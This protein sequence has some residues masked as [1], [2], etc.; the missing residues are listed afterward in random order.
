MK[1]SFFYVL[2]TVSLLVFTPF[3]TV[4]ARDLM[5]I[6]PIL[7]ENVELP[8]DNYKSKM[9]AF[10]LAQDTGQS[11]EDDFDAELMEEYGED[12]EQLLDIPDPLY[13]FNYAMYGLND[14]LY[15]ALLKPAATG[16]K[17]VMPTPARKGIRNF[18]HNLLFPVRLVN[19]MLQGKFSQAGT[20]VEIFVIN[21]TVGCLGFV[22]VAQDYHGKQ[23]SNEDLGQTFA[24][25]DIGDGFYLVLPV[26]GPSTLRDTIGSVGDYFL[27]PVN[28]AEPWELYWGLKITD[29]VNDLSFR[30]GDY[31]AL[32]EAAVDPYAA[33]KNAYIQ[34]RYKKIKE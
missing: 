26:L 1:K 15:F 18:F 32:K 34:N 21:S 19:N 24:S 33:I 25:W 4:F 6:E 13:Y 11:S 10:Y 23:T 30:L 20:E 9:I 27:T 5:T 7:Y 2:L 3:E 12:D 31:E 17:K 14:F 28:Y 8:A 22:Q 29:S 16:Y